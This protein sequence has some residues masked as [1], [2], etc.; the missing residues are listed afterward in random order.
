M[1]VELTDAARLVGV[2]RLTLNKKLKEGTL[3]VSTD[4]RGKSA[5]ST[6]ELRK[7]FGPLKV[8]HDSPRYQCL[9]PLCLCARQPAQ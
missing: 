4:R 9:C 6:A 5:V 1:N 2:S 3:S 8:V 7:V